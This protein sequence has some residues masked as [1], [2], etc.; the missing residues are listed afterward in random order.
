M[1]AESIPKVVI[2]VGVDFFSHILGREPRASHMPGRHSA[3]GVSL[4]PF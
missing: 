4:G 3:S 1:N 2:K